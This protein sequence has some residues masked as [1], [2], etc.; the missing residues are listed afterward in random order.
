MRTLWL[1]IVLLLAAPAIAA[2]NRTNAKQGSTVYGYGAG[3]LRITYENVDFASMYAQAVQ[4]RRVR[5]QAELPA[6]SPT[7]PSIPGA[8]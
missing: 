7:V 8:P 5:A 3:T 1:V 4:V 2:D 6:E